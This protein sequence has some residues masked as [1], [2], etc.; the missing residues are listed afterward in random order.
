[1]LWRLAVRCVGVV[2]TTTAVYAQAAV[3][4]ALRTGAAAASGTRDSLFI[5]ACRVDSSFI[6]CASR[7]YPTAFKLGLI[8]LC[9]LIVMALVN[10][11]RRRAFR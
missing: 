11:R 9:I 2:A 3:E 7:T 1:M 4:Y 6:S 5:G 8:G 10:H